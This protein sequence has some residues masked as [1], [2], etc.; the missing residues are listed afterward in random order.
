MVTEAV[1]QLTGIDA[2][3][4]HR[5]AGRRGSAI[6]CLEKW[7]LANPGDFE[8]AM[9]MTEIHAED[10]ADVRAAEKLVRRITAHPAFSPQQKEH[11]E[12]RLK[13][14]KVAER[15]KPNGSW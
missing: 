13:A 11:A 4:E 9:L 6:E 1:P 2:A 14:W 15:D 12:N 5:S 8:A 10:N 3:R 7:L